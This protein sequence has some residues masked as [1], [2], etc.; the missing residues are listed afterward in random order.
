[1]SERDISDFDKLILIARVYANFKEVF[2][3]DMLYDFLLDSGIKFRKTMTCRKI[4]IFLSQSKRFKCTEKK[5]NRK[6][7]EL[8]K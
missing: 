1:M 7:Y 2:S 6:F 5:C 3:P 8:V 4:G